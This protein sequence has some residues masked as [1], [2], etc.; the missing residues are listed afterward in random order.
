MRTLVVVIV[1]LFTIQV[2]AEEPVK[3]GQPVPDFTVTDLEGKS[4]KL[5]ELHTKSGLKQR[6]PIVLTFWCS[7]C[8][9]CRRVEHRL[10]KLAKQNQ[11][12]AVV[13]ALD[14]SAGETA[15]GVAAFAKKNRL[16]LPIVLDSKG[17]TAD[18][19]GAKRTTTTVV[20][21]SKGILRYRGQFAQFGHPLAANALQAVLA[22]KVVK[23]KRTK[24]KG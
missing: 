5:S 2:R 24:E 8:G 4:W 13:I 9:S 11:G 1:A 14:A 19:F 21:D 15:D 7:F 18:I 16:T 3:L 12:K 23:V 20:I 6:G 17:K 10:D 22:G